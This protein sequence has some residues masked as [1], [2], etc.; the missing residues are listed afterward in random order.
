MLASKW[1]EASQAIVSATLSKI[2]SAAVT[3][4]PAALG[5]MHIARTGVRARIPHQL[6]TSF[7][8]G[9][10][11]KTDPREAMKLCGYEAAER[12]LATYF[13]S[14]PLSRDVGYDL[15]SWNDEHKSIIEPERV[16]IG[17]T[18][19]A[20]ENGGNA[21]GLSFHVEEELAKKHA[22]FEWLERSVLGNIW[23]EDLPLLKVG[24][25][26]DEN[27]DLVV[28]EYTVL[29]SRLVPFIMTVIRSEE[30]GFFCVGARFSE[31]FEES[32]LK[33]KAEAVMLANDILR[34]KGLDN[35]ENPVSRK[36]MQSQYDPRLT[37][38][39]RDFILALTQRHVELDALNDNVSLATAISTL[40]IE[41]N[42]IF[43]CK[44]HASSEGYLIRAFIPKLF[45]LSQYR[46][47]FRHNA[48][49]LLDPIC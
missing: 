49:S 16:I 13:F 21:V 18:A 17:P 26:K 31:S 42:D 29:L 28:E 33:A 6:G 22:A 15:V 46:Q 48:R 23:Y 44:L 4:E 45:T 27:S 24:E 32:R 2:H 25:T 8:G 37:K 36:R 7:F 9:F 34:R 47:T 20:F 41:L 12:L 1:S 14:N 39:R 38:Q 3:V 40:G 43:F 35:I 10:S 5:N 11:C 19:R 30:H